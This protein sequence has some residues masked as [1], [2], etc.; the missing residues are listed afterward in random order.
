MLIENSC[1]SPHH[2]V[3]RFPTAF[4]CERPE[5]ND[6]AIAFVRFERSVT[7]GRHGHPRGPLRSTVRRLR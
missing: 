3:N 6:C 5:K 4:V 1:W 2:L 7:A